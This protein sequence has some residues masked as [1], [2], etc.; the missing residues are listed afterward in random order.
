MDATLDCTARGCP[1]EPST[2]SRRGV[3]EK[4]A[5][6]ESLDSPWTSP[7]RIA[8]Q[9]EVPARTLHYWIRRERAVIEN[10]SWPKPV[11]RFLETPEG[12]DLLHRLFTAAHLVFVEANDCGLRNLSWFLQLSGLDEF[13]APSYGAQQV[14]A[15]ELESL[16][17]RFGQEEDQRLAQHMPRREITLCEDETFHPQICLVAIEPVSNFILVEQYQPQRDADT[18]QQCVSTQLAGLPIAVCQVTSD[19]AKAI[20]AHTETYLGAH[21][22]PDLFHVQHDTVHATSGALASQTHAALREWEKS[23]QK[24]AGLRAEYDSCR[25][26]CP[27]DP[28]VEMLQH[29]VQRAEAE[30][31]AA[32]EQ[33]HACQARQACAQTARQGLGRDY[34]PVDLETGQPLTA[35][36]VGRRLTG[37]FDTLDHVAGEAGLS[38]H[39]R[40]KL[41]KARRVLDSMQ[42]TIA[43]F[44]T[45]IAARSAAWQ[46]SPAVQQWLRQDLIPAY[47]LCRVAEKADMAQERQRL[48]TLAAE[49]LARARSPDGLWGTFNPDL[50]ADLE[51]KARQCA[52]IFQRSSSCV[53][54]RNGQLS[55]RHHALHQLT[56]RKLQALT[57]L[58]NYAVH[59]ADGSTAAGRFYGATPRDLFGWLLE[60]LSLPDRPRALRRP[61]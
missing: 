21:H 18:W 14:A 60:H 23:H 32:T 17:I 20:I 24:T 19:A 6:F 46:L 52:D 34:H 44:W 48:R 30:E 13:I 43:F 28:L 11:A 38:A 56:G 22:S 8:D 47:Y 16:L 33:V 10:S 5:E 29:R 61:A 40:D 27:Q 2:R 53:E 59:R 37:H 26:Q 7:R 42:A 57:V 4:M 3:A 35:E 55:L 51:S 45:M 58:H 12:L 54:G 15:E 49:V 25:E 41:A 39:A 9:L 1:Q 31:T 36:E 50:Q